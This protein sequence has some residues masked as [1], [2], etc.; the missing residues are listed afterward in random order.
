MKEYISALTN[1]YGIIHRDKVVEIYNSQNENQISSQDLDVYFNESSEE[2]KQYFTEIHQDYFVHESIMDYDDFD[3]MLRK[4]AG[5]PYYVPKKEELLKY[6]DE[7]YF[8]KTKQY[9]DLLNYLK[10]NFLDGDEEKAEWLCEDIQ[11]TCQFGLD[12]KIIFDSFNQRGISFKDQSQVNEVMQLVMELANNI[13]IWENNG[14]TPHEIFEKYEKPNLRP[15]P[16]MPF[17]M[18]TKKEKIGRNDPCPCGSGKK[19]KKCCMGKDELN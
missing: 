14:F 6:V 1:L 3:L 19:Y 16:D 2:I 13:R 8:E 17:E 18:G 9:E 12:M 15:L 11:G 4:K 10:K 7:G 5:K